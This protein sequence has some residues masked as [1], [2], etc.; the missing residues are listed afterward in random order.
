MSETL[1]R[2]ASD[3]KTVGLSFERSGKGAGGSPLKIEL[4]DKGRGS[5]DVENGRYQRLERTTK[6]RMHG[7]FGGESFDMAVTVDSVMEFD[8]ERSKARTEAVAQFREPPVSAD[9]LA[10]Y[11]AENPASAEI[12]RAVREFG[13]GGPGA[14]LV[15]HLEANPIAIWQQAMKLPADQIEEFASVVSFQMTGSPPLPRLADRLVQERASQTARSGQS[16]S[17]FAG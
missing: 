2:T 11:L 8:A 3:G 17:E 14:L 9:E 1:K 15:F 4:D 16:D 13:D 10:R 5:F 12:A 6:L 7:D